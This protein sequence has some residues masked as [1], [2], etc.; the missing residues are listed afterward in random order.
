[1]NM[2]SLFN[3]EWHTVGRYFVFEIQISNTCHHFALDCD[4]RWKQI[5][6]GSC[7]K[8][9]SL[10]VIILY[11]ILF[12]SDSCHI[13]LEAISRINTWSWS[14]CIVRHRPHIHWTIVI[15][16]TCS[17]RSSNLRAVGRF[18][19]CCLCRSKNEACPKPFFLKLY[20]R[21]EQVFFSI[22]RVRKNENIHTHKK[23]EIE[24]STERWMRAYRWTQ[25]H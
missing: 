24:E 12:G 9:L 15:L 16:C 4:M 2:R 1:M 11:D 25:N 20:R 14:M 3:S 17:F 6:N 5:T 18:C 22:V 19:S 7:R 10:C 23:R 21:Y 8:T 13:T